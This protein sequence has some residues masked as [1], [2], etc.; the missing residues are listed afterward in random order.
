MRKKPKY[1][2]L[3]ILTWAV[4]ILLSYLFWY[5]VFQLS[6]VGWAILTITL[7]G[8]FRIIKSLEVK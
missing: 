4:V 2:P 1:K 6:T 8:L 5:F 3:I 7:I